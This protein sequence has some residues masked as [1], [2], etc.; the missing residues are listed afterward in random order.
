MHVPPR[1]DWAKKY[2]YFTS[3]T[4]CQCTGPAGIITASGAY[5]DH[6]DPAATGR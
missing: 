2:Y 4:E 1:H 5:N 3:D 6:R